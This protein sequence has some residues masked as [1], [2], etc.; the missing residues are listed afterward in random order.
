MAAIAKSEGFILHALTV[1]YGQRH[2]R[3]TSAAVDIAYSLGVEEHVLATFTIP[4]GGSALV[5]ESINIPRVLT[6]DDVIPVTYVPLRNSILLAMAMSFAEVRGAHAIFAGMNAVD[7][8]GYP[9][10]RPEFIEA[11]GLALNLGSKQGVEGGRIEIRTP[12]IHLPKHEIIE[13][14]LVLGVDYS[15]TW[16]CYEGDVEPCGECDSCRIREAAFGKLGMEY[17]VRKV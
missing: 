7:Y 3:E 12:L 16:S 8:S 17:P 1:S 11:I 6:P 10:C 5:D 4:W 9:D 14:G 15:L 2:K 13:R